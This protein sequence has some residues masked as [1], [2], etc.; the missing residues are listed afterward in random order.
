MK[1]I[2]ITD[3]VYTIQQ[4]VIGGQVLN[5]STPVYFNG[6]PALKNKRIKSIVFNR[7]TGAGNAGYIFFNIFNS[8]GEQLLTDYPAS[9][10][11]NI[12]NPSIQTRQRLFDLYDIDLKQSY[13]ID[14][15]NIPQPTTRVYFEL[16]F[17]F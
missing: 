15:L 6:Y 12:S 4:F 16:N 1:N 7:R 11:C 5:T 17:Y 14:T 2:R 8:K 13:Y 10:L 3:Q 9:D